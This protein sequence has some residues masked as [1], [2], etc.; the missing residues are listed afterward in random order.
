MK[1]IDNKTIKILFKIFL[2][3]NKLYSN[4]FMNYHSNTLYLKFFSTFDE[5]INYAKDIKFII[6][7]LFNY[8]LTNEGFIFW[9][10]AS[11]KWRSFISKIIKNE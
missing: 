6:N 4:F 2:L 10:D 8:D 3:K 7:N 11:K 1:K 9:L 5:T